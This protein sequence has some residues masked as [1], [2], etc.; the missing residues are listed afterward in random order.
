MEPEKKIQKMVVETYADDMAEV[1]ENDKQG[2]IK[3][4]IHEEEDEEAR[5]R[6]LSPE[7]RQNRMFMWVSIVF[8]LLGLSTLSYFLITR[9]PTTV[10]VEQQFVPIIFNDKTSFIEVSEFNKPEIQQT[11]LNQINKTSVKPRAVEG[12]YLTFYNQKVGLRQFI[13][14]IKSSL[15]LPP[16]EVFVSDDFLMGVVNVGTLPE[17][18][19]RPGFF[20]LI[21]MRT[22]TDIFSAIRTWEDKMFLDLHGFLGYTLNSETTYLLTKDFEDGI[23]ENKNARFLYDKDGKIVLMYVFADDNSI[24]IAN[25]EEAVKEVVLRIASKQTKE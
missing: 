6:N 8:L 19:N 21:K 16:E 17:G 2:L 14:L 7:F 18:P 24:I 5:K 22:V 1:I 12:V 20:I 23:V 9:E 4:I 15:I 25:S 13:S 10:P 11:V 3:K